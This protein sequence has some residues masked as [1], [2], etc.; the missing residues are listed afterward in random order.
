MTILMIFLKLKNLDLIMM[1]KTC[2]KSKKG[3]RSWWNVQRNLLR[4]AIEVQAEIL[5]I[6]G[7][8]ENG[9]ED[10][11]LG[12]GETKKLMPIK[13]SKKINNNRSNHLFNTHIFTICMPFMVVQNITNSHKWKSQLHRQWRN[14]WSVNK[15]RS[16]R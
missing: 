10:F 9:R 11:I 4:Y 3:K 13:M 14:K 6:L 7:G 5:T 12:G 15:K 1:S 8:G 16:K 2:K